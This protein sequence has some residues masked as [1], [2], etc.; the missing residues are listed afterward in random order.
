MV[1][2]IPIVMINLF[3]GNVCRALYVQK[4]ITIGGSA[5]ASSCATGSSQLIFRWIVLDAS[6]AV[7]P[8]RTSVYLQANTLMLPAY[9]LS[10]GKNYFAKLE[11]TES[12]GG[13]QIPDPPVQTLT[14]S[15]IVLLGLTR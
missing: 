2:N 12:V 10:P 8:L 7:V 15:H 3:T 5:F 11:V 13:C 6:Q 4:S 14:L 9:S 1:T